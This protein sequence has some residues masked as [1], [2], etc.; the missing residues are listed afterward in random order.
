MTQRSVG[1][2]GF[3]LL[4]AYFT[5]PRPKSQQLK[6]LGETLVG[7]YIFC[8]MY[9]LV[10]C[11]EDR[12]AFM[13][14]VP[15]GNAMLYIFVMLYGC[16]TLCYLPGYF[17]HDVTQGLIIVVM[18]KTLLVDTRLSYWHNK[19]RMDYWAQVRLLSDNLAI[20]TGLS[21][22][23]TCTKKQVYADP[24]SPEHLKRS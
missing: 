3:V 11:P 22:Y 21:M 2:A 24:P 10:E 8:A 7:L 16:C 4:Y 1:V 12:E 9:T 5:M 13:E 14:F 17:V 15:G 19:Q 6:R 18:L 23:L 20:I